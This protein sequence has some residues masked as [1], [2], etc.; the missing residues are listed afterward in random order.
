MCKIMAN[1]CIF[2]LLAY[3]EF[4]RQGDT[5]IQLLGGRGTRS[6]IRVHSMGV[7]EKYFIQLFNFV[8]FSGHGNSSEPDLLSVVFKQLL[9]F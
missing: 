1:S 3:N 7:L 6:C 2:G 8:T 4:C 5:K 9:K